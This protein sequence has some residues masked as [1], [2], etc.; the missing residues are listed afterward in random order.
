MKKLMRWGGI[1]LVCGII[2]LLFCPFHSWFEVDLRAV[3]EPISRWRF[4]V[5]CRFCPARWFRPLQLND[6]RVAESKG[7]ELLRIESI[8]TDR[9]LLSYLWNGRTLGTIQFNQPA[10]NVELLESESNL[11]RLIKALA[12]NKDPNDVEQPIQTSV[13]Q[14]LMSRLK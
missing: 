2:L 4:Q 10:I 8:K 5:I 14:P 6:I 1:V 13:F 11:N 9:G 7:P 12:G 3:G